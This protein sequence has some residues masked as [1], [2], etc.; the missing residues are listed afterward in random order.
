[1]IPGR[2]IGRSRVAAKVLAVRAGL[3]PYD[4]D[5]IWECEDTMD[6]RHHGW[7]KRKEVKNETQE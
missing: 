5:E 1:M 3:D 7:D 6:V 4:F 2:Q